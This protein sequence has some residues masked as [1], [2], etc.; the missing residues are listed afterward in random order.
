MS[1]IAEAEKDK[2]LVERALKPARVIYTSAA[3][4]IAYLRNSP[5]H[6]NAG[7]LFPK[8]ENDRNECL[9]RSFNTG[10]DVSLDG[11]CSHATGTSNGIAIFL[12]PSK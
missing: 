7:A 10:A 8:E 2:H 12:Q 5:Q 6:T 9:R 4:T 1:A 11:R 3:S